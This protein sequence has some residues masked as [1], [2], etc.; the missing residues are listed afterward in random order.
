MRIT[1]S[2]I[3]DYYEKENAEYQETYTMNELLEVIAHELI[4]IRYNM[5]PR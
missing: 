4:L 2:C 5:R 3:G 1:E